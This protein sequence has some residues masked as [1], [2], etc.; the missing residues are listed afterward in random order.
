MNENKNRKQVQARILVSDPLAEQGITFIKS[1]NG[2]HVDVKSKLDATEL[3]SVI[4]AYDALIVRSE[5]KVTEKVLEAGK[6]L[7][8]V[9]RAGVGL[10]NIDVNAAT[11][12]GVVVLNAP[13][14]N[15][16]STAEHAVSMMLALA[17]NIPQACS[18]VKSRKWE[19][20]RFT[21]TEVYAKTLGIIGLGR[22]GG[23]V[24]RRAHALGMKL[25]GYDPIISPEKARSLNVEPVD[26]DDLIRR[27]DFITLHVPLTDQTRNLISSR[28]F[29]IMKDDVRIINCARGG[30]VDEVALLQA[31]DSGKV[32]GAALDV[33]EKEPPL[34]SPLLDHDRVIVT[35]HLGAS[36]EEAQVSVAC[37]VADQVIRAL[38]GEPVPFA[39][40]VPPIDPEAYR[41]LKP[42][43]DLAEKLGRFQSQ[44]PLGNVRELVVEVFGEIE[45][46]DLRPIRT[47][48]I[49]GFLEVFLHE[50]VNYVNAPVLLADRK[51]AVTER[52]G[53]M[54]RDYANLITV[55]AI[56]DREENSVAGTLFSLTTPRI[57]RLNEFH[58]DIWP[59]GVVLICLNEDKPGIIGGLGTLMAN[60]NINIGAMTLGRTKRGGKAATILNLDAE[61]TAEI[62]DEVKSVKYVND[63]KV[64]IL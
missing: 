1:H 25:L 5:T 30:I 18:S 36:T 9:G 39:V 27:S 58:V 6:N 8:V 32:A 50:N 22:I 31:L 47:A 4:P 61:L 40:N 10:D 13:G 7:K 55:R 35:P 46:Y 14:G 53:K 51:I 38:R 19:R 3:L 20:K 28:Q 2:F 56:T 26:L 43:L 49:K 11:K 52:K 12:R 33:F 42:Y 60:N 34:D 63:A 17:R 48:V 64:V 37:E 54:L 59:E 62:L 44:Y 16:I 57:V 29:A 24:A 23:E 15:T 45:N 21:G 41:E